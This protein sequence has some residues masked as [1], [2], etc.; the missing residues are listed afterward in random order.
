L[1]EK[2]AFPYAARELCSTHLKKLATLHLHSF[3]FGANTMNSNVHGTNEFGALH[4]LAALNVMA[5]TADPVYEAVSPATCA[6]IQTN[7]MNA[8]KA[9]PSGTT[10]E[11]DLFR[12]R[13]LAEEERRISGLFGEADA[14]ILDADIAAA[15]AVVG[16][17]ASVK[18]ADALH[19]VVAK[20]NPRVARTV[21]IGSNF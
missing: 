2:E 8:A 4:A 17:D 9:T 19:V 18:L 16:T 21:A 1:T 10:H 13:H 20:L 3:L 12:L 11:T 14:V 7:L 15:K 6:Q 5:A